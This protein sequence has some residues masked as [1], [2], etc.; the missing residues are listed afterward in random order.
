MSSCG[1]TRARRTIS[2]TP[3]PTAAPPT[4]STSCTGGSEATPRYAASGSKLS[5][6]CT[7]RP[8][9]ILTSSRRSRSAIAGDAEQAQIALDLLAEDVERALGPFPAGGGD[10]VQR[11]A[12]GE[13]RV[14]AEHHRLHDIGAAP[15]AAIGEQ[16]RSLADRPA[17][18]GQDVERRH[19]PVELAPAMV[20]DRHRVGAD[21]GG[22]LDVLAPTTAP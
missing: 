15:E 3:F 2:A 20:R 4:C 19:R 10:P 18:P 1:S 9:P 14:G 17:R 22:A 5:A 13:H 11:G 8:P 16:R 12:A 7:S 21:L 6:G